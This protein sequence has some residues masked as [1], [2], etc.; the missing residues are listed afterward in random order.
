MY[1]WS[2]LGYELMQ[3]PLLHGITDDL[4]LA[5]GAV[6]PHI[7]D[8]RA[9]ICVI[10]EVRLLISVTGLEENYAA[11]GR[12]WHG[13]RTTSNGVHWRLSEG[14]PDPSLV[15]HVPESPYRGDPGNLR[16]LVA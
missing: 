13:R 6:E 7:K 10:E 8:G 15:Y 1:L 14:T 4:A 9:F 3:P 11:T 5:M 2:L 12:R 16:G